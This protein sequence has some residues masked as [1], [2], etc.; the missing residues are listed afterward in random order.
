MV[1]EVLDSD[2]EKDLA[3]DALAEQTAAEDE[4]ATLETQAAEAYEALVTEWEQAL[5]QVPT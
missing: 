3:D 5:Q 4:A 1:E 2:I